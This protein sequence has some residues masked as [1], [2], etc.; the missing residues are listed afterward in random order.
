M[1]WINR[2]LMLLLATGGLAC[3][4]SRTSGEKPPQI[5]YLPSPAQPCLT[6]PPPP[7]P[8]LLPACSPTLS[9]SQCPNDDVNAARML[10]Y[11]HRLDDYVRLY[12]WPV[13]QAVK[14]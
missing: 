4:G 14:A 9:P 6:I 8:E 1:R 13:C 2:S 7:R 11:L 3:C 10:D 12:V 5:R